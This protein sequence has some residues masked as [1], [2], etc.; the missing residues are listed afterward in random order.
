MKHEYNSDRENSKLQ[1]N[2]G[3]K[4]LQIHPSLLCN[5]RCDHC[6]S[7]SS[8]LASQHLDR[9]FV[10]STI[11]NAHS[12]GYKNLSISGGEPLLYPYLSDA[13]QK[14][15]QLRMTTSLITNGSLPKE[16][17]N[18]I[19]TV[20]DTIGVSIDGAPERHN[21]IRGNKNSFRKLDMLIDH[22]VNEFSMVGI[23]FTLTDQ[24][25]EDLPYLIEYA[26]NKKVSALQI[27]PL[28]K[29]GRA[30]TSM[31]T[32]SDATI[33]RAFILSRSTSAALPV[34][35]HFNCFSKESLAVQLSQQF[36][37]FEGTMADQI[38]LI[39][40]NEAGDL[41]PYTYGLNSRW[42]IAD[43][44]ESLNEKQWLNYKKTTLDTLNHLC[45]VTFHRSIQTPSAF[46]RY[47]EQLKQHS[48]YLPA[49]K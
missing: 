43:R 11:E 3:R 20:L 35:V 22:L 30:K 14:A 10:L 16:K 46:I 31:H 12:L 45:E 33:M 17:Y 23:A 18:T 7:S 13:L 34:N 41:M 5:F 4:M 29:D 28:E 15:K 49:F 36:N 26:L 40:L 44:N 8:P 19:S 47:Y 9:S 24:S 6:Y 21:N 42:R 27:Y 39:V 48:Q 2:Q 32:L 25:W 37:S 1:V 38:D